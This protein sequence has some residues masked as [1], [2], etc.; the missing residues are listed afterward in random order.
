MRLWDE[1]T[2]KFID[3]NQCMPLYALVS[4]AFYEELKSFLGIEIGGYVHAYHGIV[5][6]V[7]SVPDISE[8]LI[9]CGCE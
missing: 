8:D 1:R 3:E 7:S 2:K 9:F 6:Y 5:I 4:P